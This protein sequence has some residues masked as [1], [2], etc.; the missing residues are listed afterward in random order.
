[1]S[2]RVR[3][4]VAGVVTISVVI[5]VVLF[6]RTAYL[7]SRDGG[8][9]PVPAAAATG[10]ATPPPAG[11]HIVFRSTAPGP[12]YGLVAAVSLDDPAGPRASTGV[13]CDRVDAVADA[14]SC[15]RTRRGVVTTFEAVLLDGSWEESRTW[16]LA[17]IPSRT[18][19][20]AA[21][22][23]VATT[24]F[25]S[26]HSYAATGFSTQTEVT[27][28]DGESLGNLEEFTLLVDGREIAP[29]D[30]NIW[31]VTFAGGDRFYATAASA[32]LGRTW[33]VEGDLRARTLT[34]VR[35][36]VECP[37]LSPDGSRIAYKK[38]VG[39]RH[40]AIAVL[41]LASGD[42]SVLGENR[43]VDDQVAWLDDAT[44]LYGLPR[45]GEAGAA[46]VW[47]IRTE[48]GSQPDV[49]IPDA[50]SPAV[51]RE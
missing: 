6:V 39:D 10:P 47:S 27:R 18:R 44:L 35:E 48:P 25:V 51:V 7:A 29:V 21:G 5:A 34:A 13:A 23:L 14:V 11:A 1:M 2:A 24:A 30:R 49:L 33:L 8:V 50:W 22:D 31:G 28:T 36:D 4:V 32:A 9:S 42:E 45:P 38:D 46:D 26:G 16:P 40:W 43:S 19:L 20:S 41:D 12:D 15:L 3:A 37:S 17:G